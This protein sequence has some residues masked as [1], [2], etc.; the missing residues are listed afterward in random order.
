VTAICDTI[1]FIIFT[2][3]HRS[4]F[5]QLSVSFCCFSE[6]ERQELQTGGGFTFLQSVL[7][8]RLHISFLHLPHFDFLR[9]P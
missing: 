7:P 4:F 3:T 8:Q 5:V 2:K 1:Y 6:E 9:S